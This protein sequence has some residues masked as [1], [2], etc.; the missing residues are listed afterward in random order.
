MHALLGLHPHFLMTV[1]V[2]LGLSFLTQPQLVA[3]KRNAGMESEHA[4]SSRTPC[5]VQ[6]RALLLRKMRCNALPANVVLFL[7]LHAF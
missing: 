1:R 6:I 7:L 5:L 4:D 2:R 3:C